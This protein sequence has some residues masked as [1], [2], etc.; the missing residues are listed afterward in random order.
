[1]SLAKF[2]ERLRMAFPEDLDWVTPDSF[3]RAVAT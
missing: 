1:M 2:R 3:R